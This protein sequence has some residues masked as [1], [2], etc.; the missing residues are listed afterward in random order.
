MRQKGPGHKPTLNLKVLPI[1]PFMVYLIYCHLFQVHGANVWPE[2][3][4][5]PR[6]TGVH[7]NVLLHVWLTPPPSSRWHTSSS[8][9]TDGVTIRFN[10]PLFHYC[11]FSTHEQMNDFVL[12]G[13]LVGNCF[14][15]DIWKWTGL[16]GWYVEAT[17]EIMDKKYSDWSFKTIGY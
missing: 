7:D 14:I 17:E 16:L 11:P 1:A 15:E 4:W 9:H 2:Q 8:I 12:K 13:I 6:Q 3:R 5:Q 10:I